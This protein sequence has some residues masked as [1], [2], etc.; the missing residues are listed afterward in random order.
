MEKENDMK[1]EII[2]YLGKLNAR[3]I[4][5]LLKVAKNLYYDMGR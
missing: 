2:F 1:K 5:I 3:E 4:S